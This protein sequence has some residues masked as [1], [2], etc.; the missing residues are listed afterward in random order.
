MLFSLTEKFFKPLA[1]PFQTTSRLLD[2]LLDLCLRH[3][4]AFPTTFQGLSV[5][6]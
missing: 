3:V 5:P 2:S 4:D 6:D 1:S